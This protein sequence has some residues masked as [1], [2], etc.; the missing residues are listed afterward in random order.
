MELADRPKR[1]GDHHNAFGVLRLFLAALVIVSHT[2]ELI[3]G[4]PNREVLTRLTGTLS[5]GGLAVFGFFIVSGYLITGSFVQSSSL[6]SFFK[7]R[8][9]R[10]YPAFIVSSFVCLFAVAP[11]AGTQLDIGSPRILIGSIVRIAILAQPRVEGAFPGQ[12][13][14]DPISALNGA[15]WTIQYEF[16]CYALAALLGI[17][18]LYRKR[19]GVALLALILLIAAQTVPADAVNA[20]TKGRAFAGAPAFLF[21]LPGMFL[22]GATFYL[23][24]DC[25]RLTVTGSIFAAAGLCITLPIAPLTDIGVAVF[26]G[27]LLFTAA[28]LGGDTL[29][30]RINDRNDISYG[31]YLYAW[32]IEQL[33][34]RYMDSASLFLIGTM[35]L[36]LALACGWAS[37]LIVERPVLLWVKRQRS[38]TSHRSTELSGPS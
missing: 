1:F 17:A 38:A 13:Y 3:D 8:T 23:Y 10:I 15:A 4:S 9:A 11:L 31:L 26:G 16:A 20:L 14:N 36:L 24:R 27:Y 35:T 25:L 5:F 2:P 29:I 37:W 34:I 22:T 32:P 33:L 21:K 28:R 7:K 18:G 6:A 12:H 30:G 19:A